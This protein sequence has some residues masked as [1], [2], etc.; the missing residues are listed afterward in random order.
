MT[1]MSRVYFEAA[2]GR[3]TVDKASVRS[4]NG[5]NVA[6]DSTRHPLFVLKDIATGTEM[7]EELQMHIFYDQSVLEI[8]FNERTVVTSRLYPISIED[9]SLQ[10]FAE[11]MEEADI[12]PLDVQGVIWDGLEA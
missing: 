11:G 3:I 4:V 12:A 6:P 7:E 9:I 2:D 8:F 5:A 10:L 1:N